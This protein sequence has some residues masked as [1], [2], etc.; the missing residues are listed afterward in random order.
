MIEYIVIAPRW[1]LGR[2]SELSDQVGKVRVA[3]FLG[4]P[5][6]WEVKLPSGWGSK[7][8]SGK[9]VRPIAGPHA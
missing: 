4:G 7:W 8:P 9:G 6:V 5:N 1:L 3:K 2:L